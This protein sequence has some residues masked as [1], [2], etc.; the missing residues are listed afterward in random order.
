MGALNKL[1]HSDPKDAKAKEKDYLLGDGG[2][3]FLRVRKSG[4]K[5]WI[6]VYSLHEDRRKHTLGSFPALSLARARELAAEARTMIANGLHPLDAERHQI[7]AE[8]AKAQE[9]KT[10]AIPTTVV[11]LF[12]QWDALYL[13]KNHSDGGEFVRRLFENHVKP[14]IGDLLL[15]DLRTRHIA[16]LLDSTRSKGVTRTCGLVLSNI[17]QMFAFGIQREWLLRDPSSALKASDWNGESVE[18]E[19]HLDIDELFELAG[20]LKK[21]TLPTRWKLAIKLLLSTGNRVG[22]T[23]LAR[24]E[25]ISFENGVWRIPPENQKK[26]N[27]VA[28]PQTH[29][30]D[31]SPFS[32]EVIA[33]LVLL[34]GAQDDAK[35]VF[36]FPA[37]GNKSS[38]D[39]K[40]LTKAV[41]ARQLDKQVDGKTPDFG[42]LKL[43]GG[44]WTPH[45]LRRTTATLM[46][47]LG[48]ASDVIDKCLNHTEK[49]RIKRI[50][51]RAK[52]RPAMRQA[53][54]LVGEKLREVFGPVQESDV[55][56]SEEE[57]I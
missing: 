25:H 43:S 46:G 16:H 12:Q 26:T 39:E 5:S 36:L 4:Q 20:V 27:Q 22:E 29:F 32:K 10:G 49:D 48:V 57:D 47:E 21:S 50:Y 24:I 35:P 52:Q 34:Q 28:V 38:V 3:L 30:V 8:K 2:G 18:I 14:V 42:D 23:L 6:L 53:W 55:L 44:R 51:Q 17:R 9:V 11:E 1:K 54:L 37:K 13:S 40:T 33:E 41:R 7:A 15:P 31:L 19:R 56:E 45:D